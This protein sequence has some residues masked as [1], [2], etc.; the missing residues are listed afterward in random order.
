M[1]DTAAKSLLTAK[2]HAD[3]VNGYMTRLVPVDSDEAILPAYR[4][5]AIE[6]L[7]RYHNLGAPLPLTTGHAQML[8]SMCMDHRKD[9]V[10]PGEFAY[11]LRT[12]GGNLRDS[13]FE[14]SYA[15][16]VGGV[17]TL[18]LFA[19]TDCGMA[20]VTQKRADFV[21]GLVKRGG[22]TPDAAGAHFDR[23]AER[24][25]IGDPVTFVCEEAQR[26]QRLYP[27]VLIVPMLYDVGTD[28][29]MQVMES[30]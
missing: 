1:I 19:H 5:T 10:L 11:V 7:L 29:L 15:I 12:A 9:L 22:W 25:Q 21:S 27:P 4:G 24:Y 20:H 26:L 18:A 14:V 2:F 17:A 6:Q 3:N 23:Y 28:R 30:P 13:E 8:I 16:G